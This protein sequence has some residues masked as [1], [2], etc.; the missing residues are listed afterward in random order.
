MFSAFQAKIK[1]FPKK[2]N[3]TTTGV[4][5]KLIGFLSQD[6]KVCKE[7]Y[8]A[9]LGSRQNRSLLSTPLPSTN[10][11]PFLLGKSFT[12]W[13]PCIAF[14]KILPR[15]SGTDVEFMMFLTNLFQQIPAYSDLSS[16]NQVSS[17]IFYIWIPRENNFFLSL[18]SSN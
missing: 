10:N 11:T 16:D 15:L 14:A 18:G 9:E 13:G 12:P 6:H 2:W 1:E 17:L 5:E 8:K 7:E 4:L 3:H